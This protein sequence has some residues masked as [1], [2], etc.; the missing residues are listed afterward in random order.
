MVQLS[1]EYP[2]MS[3]GGSHMGNISITK[4]SRQIRLWRAAQ[5]R[6]IINIIEKIMFKKSIFIIVIMLLSLSIGHTVEAQEKPLFIGLIGDS[7]V[8]SMYGWGPAFAP[9]FNSKVKVLDYA[10]NGATLESLSKKL[11]ELI[12]QKPNYILIQFGHNDM[13]RYD[14]KAYRKKLKDYV[15]RAIRGGSK[16]IVL[17]SVTRRKFDEHGKIEPRIINDRTL[18]DYALAAQVVA[19][20]MKVPFVDLN[21][22]SIK[23][24]NKIGPKNSATYNFREDDTTHFSKQGA[25]AI[26]DLIIKELKTVAS[27]L[28]V[29]LK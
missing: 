8:A 26:S 19:K 16:V 21:S 24:H 28:A 10:K 20:E 6:I 23:H 4:R 25:K 5:L 12:M 29:F 27:E 14:T 7:T 17:S 18:P 11:N 9:Q 1:I 22:I 13:K 3:L 2:V 15:E